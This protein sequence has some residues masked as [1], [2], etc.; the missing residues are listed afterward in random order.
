MVVYSR[1]MKGHEK[2]VSRLLTSLAVGVL[3][4]IAS[5]AYHVEW[6]LDETKRYSA[7]FKDPSVL[8]KADVVQKS[9]ISKS[10]R[11]RVYGHLDKQEPPEYVDRQEL[12]DSDP[13][14][15]GAEPSITLCGLNNAVEDLPWPTRKVDTRGALFAVLFDVDTG[16]FGD[17][18]PYATS[19]GKWIDIGGTAANVAIYSLIVYVFL[20][21]IATIKLSR[22]KKPQAAQIRPDTKK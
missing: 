7:R 8:Y 10:A 21:I 9:F 12:I 5:L 1:H 3:L 14:P 22:R 13:C 16:I 20:V 18:Q 4:T 11:L 6:N 15:N 17:S 2:I 19:D